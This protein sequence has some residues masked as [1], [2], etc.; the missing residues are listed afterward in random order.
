MQVITCASY[1][2]VPACA[3]LLALSQDSDVE[4]IS[5]PPTSDI[6]FAMSDDAPIET[7]RLSLVLLLPATLESL[8]GG[9]VEGASRLQGFEFT[10]DFLASVN[11]AF[12]TIQLWGILK[13]PSA[14][15]WSVRAILRREDDQLIG[16]CGFHGAPQHV[17]RA[18]IGY[19]IFAPFRRRGY[20][21]E[22]ARGLVQWAKEQGSTA[23]VAAV[24]PK[25]DSS[26][27]VVRRLSF[28]QIGVRGDGGE[29]Q[30]LVFELIV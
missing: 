29:G 9:D 6:C 7:S 26:L 12:L 22:S 17:G 1:T 8:L 15:G 2:Q 21:T 23:V 20:A 16:H 13:S 11:E 24:S 25:N 18:E 4:E 5:D 30:E 19:T 28:R 27:A 14:P 3:T 10:H